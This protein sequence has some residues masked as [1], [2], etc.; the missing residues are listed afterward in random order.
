MENILKKE[1]MEFNKR[2]GKELRIVFVSTFIIA[3]FRRVDASALNRETEHNAVGT[4]ALEEDGTKLIV[5][6]N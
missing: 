5:A 3:K 4:I 6:T 1:K 2:E